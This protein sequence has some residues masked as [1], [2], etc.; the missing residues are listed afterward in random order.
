MTEIMTTLGYSV[1]V[2]LSIFFIYGLLKIGGNGLLNSLSTSS[3]VESFKSGHPD[4]KK[5]ENNISDIKEQLAVAK[6]TFDVD[7]YDDVAVESLETNMKKLRYDIMRL[8]FTETFDTVKMEDLVND[9]T[10]TEKL[11]AIVKNK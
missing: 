5:L 7:D 2:L 8:G 3:V 11:L 6:E 10:S 1:V 9:Y 4:V